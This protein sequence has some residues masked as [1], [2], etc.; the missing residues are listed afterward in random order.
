VGVTC[1]FICK[2]NVYLPAAAGQKM[3]DSQ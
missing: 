3:G 1:N 2:L